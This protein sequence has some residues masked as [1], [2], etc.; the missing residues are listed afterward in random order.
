[1]KCSKHLSNKNKKLKTMNGKMTTNS[2]LSTTEPKQKQKQKRKKQSKLEQN[3]ITEMEITWKVISR[4]GEQG[5][6]GNRY[7]E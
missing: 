1:M 2:Q 5:E 7:R 6:W 4:E 3:R